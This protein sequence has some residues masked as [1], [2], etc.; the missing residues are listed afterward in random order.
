M[1]DRFEENEVFQTA[2]TTNNMLRSN[3]KWW[4][5][6]HGNCDPLN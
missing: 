2:H 3:K 5:C 6:Y 4:L 1:M